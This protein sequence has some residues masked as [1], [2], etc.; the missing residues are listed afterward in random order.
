MRP[1]PTRTFAPLALL[2]TLLAPSPTAAQAT[3][4]SPSPLGTNLSMLREWSGEWPF[5]DAFKLSRPW[6]AGERFGC[7]DCAGTLDL[8]AHGWVRSLDTTRPNG[9]QVANTLVFNDA[10][11]RYASGPYLVLYDGHGTLEYG[12]SAS[13]NVGAS[14]PGRDVVDV[15][16]RLGNFVL[17]LVATDPNDPLRN[18]RVLPP[19]GACANERT[20]ACR[21]D[22]DC[23]ASTCV[24]FE[25]TYTSEIFHPTF[26]A[27]LRPYRLIRFMDWM[28]VNAST[29]VDFADHA[30]LD[31]ARWWTVPPEVIAELANRLH[32]DAWISFPIRASDAFV[33]EVA[34]RIQGRLEAGRRVYVEYGNEVW[35]GTYPYSMGVQ[36]TAQRGCE[37]YPELA[38]GCDQDATPGN[39]VY[40][41]DYPW[42]TPSS[43]CLLATRRYFSAR[44]VEI[45]RLVERALGSRARVVRVMAS[46][47]GNLGHHQEILSWQNAAAETD[48]LAVAPYFGFRYGLDAT[49]GSWTLD[50]LFADLVTSTTR[51][52]PAA[53]TAMSTD[54][55]WLASHYPAIGL[56]TYEGGQHLEG[57]GTN[58]SDP[59]MN[60]LFDAANRDPRMGELLLDYLQ[61]WKARGGG[62]FVHFKNVSQWRPGRAGALEYQDQPHGE[63][64]KYQALEQFVASQPCWWNG[65]AT[66]PAEIFNEPFETGGLARWSHRRGAGE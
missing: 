40:C 15:D 31:D 66:L 53:Y 30:Q 60:A 57:V 48:V 13:K 47:S 50:Q 17:R 14:A 39:G 55:A 20:L 59:A 23:S 7:W 19:G 44:T 25:Q 35:N 5:V 33:D 38:A 16:S 1:S 61:E 63:S 62:L 37:R 43:T 21:S 45:W 6:L 3:P 54:L 9:G 24:P 12:G 4:P 32:V 64:F 26:L 36:W 52:L 65:C 8:D 27:N 46:Q 51:G 34:T 42:P 2:A 28:G 10:I 58:A 22:A 18:I 11:G 49:V 41:E 56:V 29:I